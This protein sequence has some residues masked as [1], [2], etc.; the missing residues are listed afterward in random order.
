MIGIDLHRWIY[1]QRKHLMSD[2]CEFLTL[3]GIQ[4]RY[5]NELE[6]IDDDANK[7]LRYIQ[8]VVDFF[9]KHGLTETQ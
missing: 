3:Y 4:P 1:S 9:E 6:I 2:I 8:T 5:P 7:A